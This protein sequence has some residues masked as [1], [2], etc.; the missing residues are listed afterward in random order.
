M[1]DTGGGEKNQRG[2][3]G[4]HRD[5]SRRVLYRAKA[6]R[7]ERPPEPPVPVLAA[8]ACRRAVR[9]TDVKRAARSDARRGGSW[10]RD[11]E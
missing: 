5:G 11:R 4:T 1:Q 3:G 7:A 2:G 6:T 9:G 10:R 8:V